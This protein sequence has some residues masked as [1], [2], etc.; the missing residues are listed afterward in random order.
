MCR[1]QASRQHVRNT[2]SLMYLDCQSCAR[3]THDSAHTTVTFKDLG[4]DFLVEMSYAGALCGRYL[5]PVALSGSEIPTASVARPSAASA[6]IARRQRRSRRAVLLDEMHSTDGGLGEVRPGADEVADA[7]VDDGAWVGI[8]EQFGHIAFGQPAAVVVDHR[9]DVGGLAVDWDVAWPGQR[10][11]AGL[12]RV[13][14]RLPVVVHFFVAEL[15]RHPCGQ[16]LFD[17]DVL[18]QH[19]GLA[20]RRSKAPKHAAEI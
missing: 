18:L 14:E 19:H 5:G 10:R 15:A 12:P 20:L 16:N 11:P 7:A 1:Q 3:R 2:S 4:A 13:D 8:N 9:C 17:E 6:R